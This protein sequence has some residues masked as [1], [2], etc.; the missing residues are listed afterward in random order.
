MSAP[1]RINTLTGT[2]G[3]VNNGFSADLAFRVAR[4]VDPMEEFLSRLDGRVMPQAVYEWNGI[5]YPAQGFG[6]NSELSM[7][8]SCEIAKTNGVAQIN[9]TPRGTKHV[10]SGYSQGAIAA[11]MIAH[12]FLPGGEID[13]PEDLLL[14]INFGDPT[15]PE[16][17]YPGG[18][19]I[20]RYEWHPELAKILL[21]YNNPADMYGIAPL[22][23]YLNIGFLALKQFKLDLGSMVSI[24]MAMIR[25]DEFVDAI[26][27]L[28]DPLTPGFF[29]TIMELT[30][31]GRDEAEALVATKKPVTGGV[32]GS[33]L[34][35]GR[36][37]SLAEMSG[38]V[39][40]V[41][42]PL[43]MGLGFLGG[44]IGGIDGLGQFGQI[45]GGLLG[46]GSGSGGTNRGW[47]KMG[48]TFASLL[49]F[50]VSG[51]HMRYWDPARR[52]W[53]GMTAI[54]HAVLQLNRLAAYL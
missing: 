1:V 41:G 18:H 47:V 13:R 53:D 25:N 23:T 28:L 52:G 44:L 51:D 39:P 43:G 50:G 27:E 10:L 33:L 19:G 4:P 26:V 37:M 3:A 32:L 30:G 8:E 12:E 16:G 21:S 7:D 15:C 5:D 36:N 45:T 40:I 29:D 14:V 9:R 35:G 42:A 49:E 6:I 17:F 11:Y 31:L 38:V 24:M 2:W 48:N 46:G 54:D 22:D 20:T 34:S